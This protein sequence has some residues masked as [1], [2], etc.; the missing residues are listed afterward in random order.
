MLLLFYAYEFFAIYSRNSKNDWKGKLTEQELDIISITL[1][2]VAKNYQKDW[3]GKEFWPK[4]AERINIYSTDTEVEMPLPYCVLSQIKERLTDNYRRIFFTSK[5]GHQQYAQSIMF[6]S[7]A[8]KTSVE[9]FIRLAWTLY[10]S[11]FSFSYD[12][13]ADRG[14]CSEIIDKLAKKSTTDSD[15]DDDIQIGGS[16]YR[17][18]AALKYGFEQDKI[19]STLLLRRILNYINIVYSEKKDLALKAEDDYLAGLVENTIRALLTPSLKKRK[20]NRSLPTV[21]KTSEINPVFLT[22]NSGKLELAINSIRLDES[23]IGSQES[24]LKVWPIRNG[25]PLGNPI[26]CAHPIVSNDFL[27]MVEELKVC[28]EPLL[29]IPSEDICL[30]AVL[31]VDGKGIYEKNIERPFILIKGKHEVIG[32]CR[33]DSYTIYFSNLFNPSKYLKIKDGYEQTGQNSIFFIS[34]NG[35]SITSKKKTFFFRNSSDEISFSFGPETIDSGI[36]ALIQEKENEET[37][38]SVYQKMDFLVISADKKESLEK[39]QVELTHNGSTS[40]L[41]LAGALTTNENNMT[42]DLSNLEIEKRYILRLTKIDNTGKVVMLCEPQKFIIAPGAKYCLQNKKTIVPF[43]EDSISAQWNFI[44]FVGTEVIKEGTENAMIDFTNND[45]DDPNNHRIMFKNNEYE[46]NFL[47][48][49]ENLRLSFKIPYFKWAIDEEELI[50]HSLD[51]DIWYGDIYNNEL[52]HAESSENFKILVNG[53]SLLPAKKKGYFQLSNGFFSQK[54]DKD[55]SVIAEIYQN[56]KKQSVPLFNIIRHPKF[57]LKNGVKDLFDETDEGIKL[58]FSNCY[59]GPSNTLFHIILKPQHMT[60]KPIEFEGNYCATDDFPTLGRIPDN[61]YKVTI[62]AEYSTN[63]GLEKVELINN[64]D[65]LFGSENGFLYEGVSFLQF[66][67][68]RCPNGTQQKF[69][70][71][72]MSISNIHYIEDNELP[73]YS[74]KLKTGKNKVTEVFF[75]AKREDNILLYYKDND[76]L[77]PMSCTADGS[78]FVKCNPDGK[79]YFM[80]RSIYCE[81]E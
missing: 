8:P 78:D 35:D 64:E 19:S 22:D 44:C 66:K 9:A 79:K 3:R 75:K 48:E 37:L 34:N 50:S 21:N 5:Q 52:I 13:K 23:Y 67:K 71:N 77:K 53:V 46:E 60:T 55:Y 15:L 56:D 42:I 81:V 14:L 49:G 16:F 1:I 70:R 58:L 57:S 29:K 51:S 74:G 2:L 4:I 28:I 76:E 73:T 59:C 47:K 7:Y 38:Y 27:P 17:I 31:E 33:P 69:K 72:P 62:T 36:T 43:G 6:Q 11:V 40:Y 10:C 65:I 45:F 32:D 61:D 68:Y 39:T 20:H 18:R 12:D 30:H 80:S 54:N 63:D 24:V 26:L 25:R 41:K